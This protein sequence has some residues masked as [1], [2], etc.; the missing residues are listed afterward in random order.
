M[1]NSLW[2][3]YGLGFEITKYFVEK[4]IKV[5]VLVEEKKN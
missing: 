2:G 1:C 4:K 5:I 3:T